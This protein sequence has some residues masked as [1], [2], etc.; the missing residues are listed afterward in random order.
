MD[1][2]LVFDQGMIVEMGSHQELMRK[3]GLYKT[4]LEA[5]VGGFLPL[6]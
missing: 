1:R 4:L 2:I 3:R 6:S 5:Q